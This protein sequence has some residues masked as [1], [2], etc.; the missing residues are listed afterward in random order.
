MLEDISICVPTTDT[1]SVRS[2]FN[3]YS[4]DRQI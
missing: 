2:Y 1:F 4:N 3:L